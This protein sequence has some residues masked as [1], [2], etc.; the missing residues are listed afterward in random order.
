MIQKTTLVR[1]GGSTYLRI[2]PSMLDHCNIKE[3]DTEM[4]IQDEEGKHGKFFS[5]WKKKQND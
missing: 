1:M 3:T 2:T 4:E 5:A